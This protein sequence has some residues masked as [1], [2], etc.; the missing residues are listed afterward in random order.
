MG[1]AW[2][3]GQLLFCGYEGLEP[4][5]DLLDLVA[6]GRV[7]GV[8]TFA[9]NIESPSQLRRVT[10]HLAELAPK[11]APLA[12]AVDQEGGRVQRLRAPWTQWP[13]M[14]ALGRADDEQA[15]RGFARA[16]G[17]E[18]R[19][20]GFNLDF[21]PVVDVHSNPKN[22]VIGDRSFSSEPDV[23]ARHAVAVIEG[24]RE[25][26]VA[27][28]AKHFPGHGDTDLD[29]HLELPVLNHNLDR[30]RR[31]EWP[32][33]VAAI[34]AGVASLMSAHISF[35][36]LDGARPATLSP[37]IMALV[38]DELGF[39]GVVFSDDLEMGAVAR[40]Y[41]PR[42]RIEGCLTAGLDGLLVCRHAD[43]R[44][45]ALAILERQRDSVLEGPLT[46]MVA[47]KSGLEAAGPVPTR[48][49]PP[50]AEHLQM[51]ETWQS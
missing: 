21:A 33:F 12:I 38:R 28:C 9:R 13:P 37:T 40:H 7:G 1:A 41:S 49:G 47:F 17:L 11:G 19:E 5:R 24:L 10:Q 44:D 14:A 51:A 27:A 3:P 26:G 23:V 50:Y 36:A 35:P 43:F 32:P 29:S 42:A 15:S 22:P 2:Q 25:A 48:C 34:Q 20:A 4:P 46:R 30:L 45:E 18:L 39:D 31:I 8:I 6:A 16:L